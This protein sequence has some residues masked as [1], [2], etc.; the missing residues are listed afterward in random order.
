MKGKTLMAVNAA[1]LALI[2]LFS[3]FTLL[4]VFVIPHTYG[5]VETTTAA[6]TPD[7][8]GTGTPETNEA[9]HTGSATEQISGSPEITTS[10]GQ[11]IRENSDTYYHDDNITVEIVQYRM[12]DTDIYV[13]DVRIS[14]LDYLKTAFAYN[15]FGRNL[16]A[17]T[18]TMAA[19]NSAILAVNGDYYGARNSGFVVRGGV[20]YR[21]SSSGNEALAIF[22]D[23][24]FGFYNEKTTSARTLVSQGARDV[25]SFGP[26]IV[27]GGQVIV[28]Q[29]TE[30]G[31]AMASNPRT[32]IGRYADDGFHYVFVV[33]D[34]R[35]RNS[36]GLTLYQLATF[37]SSTLGVDAAYNLDG[38][39]S[40]TMVFRGNIINN[41]TTNGRIQERA[42]S[43]IVYVG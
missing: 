42:V 25:F 28:S 40:S 9:P 18:S 4:D 13:A 10:P 31:H 6:N 2:V 21:D 8:P 37:M 12:Y 11:T 43:D 41:P 38:G 7:E 35:V 15:K 19:Q 36:S 16:T 24:T 39:G 17:K 26:G 22:Q 5:T 27:Q 33:S 20:V 29:T 32:A 23:G 1:I 30:V 34:G 14:S 3:G